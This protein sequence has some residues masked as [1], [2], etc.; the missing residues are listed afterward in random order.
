MRRMKAVTAV[1]AALAAALI[2][3]ILIP[4]CRREQEPLD[5]N[6]APDTYLTSS[7]TETTAT[8][9]RVRM[10]WHG[11]DNDGVV[12]RY[13]WYISDTLLTL[14]P[15][16]NPDAEQRDWNPAERIADYLR[17]RFTTQTDTVIIFK[18]YD[19]KKLATVNR[20]AFHIAS[21]DDGGRIDPTPARIQFFARVRGVPT[22]Q[23]WVNYGAADVPYNPAAL[24]TISM[25]AP[26]TIK[27]IGRTINN[28]ITGY[29]WSYGGKVL[30]DYN[31]DGNPDWYVPASQDEVVSTF[32]PNEGADA[33]P[34]GA[35]N[36]KV[37]AR[38]EAGALSRSD[39][40]SG[41]GV[42]RIVINH[43]P[44]T[45]ILYGDCFYTP[46]S[47]GTPESLRV[48]FD[49]A[50]PDTL[51]YNSLLRMR[52][53]G[54][55]D[56][57]DE[58]AND[59]PLPIRFQFAYHRW[60]IDE[61]GAQV[62]FKQSPWY[63]LKTPEDTNPNAD[64]E[65]DDRDVDSTT[66]RVGT[67]N[68]RFL[69]RSFDEQNRPDGSPA[70]VTFT[71]NFPPRIDSVRVGFV[72]QRFGNF[73]VATMDTLRIG[74]TG[75]PFSSRGD[76][77]CPYNITVITA[78]GLLTKSFK[79][80]IRARGHDDRRDPAGAGIKGWRYYVSDPEEDRLYYKEGEWQFDRALNE[81][82][83]E[84]QFS[85]T[86]PWKR[87]A[88][89]IAAQTDSILANPPLFL[90]QQS[91]T[92]IGGDVRDTETFFE[93]IRGISPKFDSE[94]NVIPANNW[95]TNEYYFANYARRD[96]YRGGVYLKLVK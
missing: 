54:W 69:A 7:P 40:I 22:V 87:T 32:L 62:A 36:F 37:I 24:D 38:D 60:A 96:T 45:E 56:A 46:L 90:G 85:I 13:I 89:E 78:A 41:E 19:D 26:F 73:H 39:I 33:L 31:N 21:I 77:L 83:Q 8:D 88:G 79:F 52:Y 59:P 47:T 86:V 14:D 58:L 61:T 67:F 81:L 27:F 82:D 34:S 16:E 6:K 92:V 28:V 18:G 5:R 65:D 42:C 35:F 30:P 10:Y 17:G 57:G 80:V 74:W 84:I 44:D 91:Y 3:L 63:P 11:G 20:Q 68:Y 29:R 48:Y 71:G 70:I 23:F 25:F 15:D 12:T 53:R 76:T 94:G 66:M 2:L 95:I 43:D 4:A 93:G 55:D 64:V 49:D 75:L 51:P 9:Y 72:D 1:E 50:I